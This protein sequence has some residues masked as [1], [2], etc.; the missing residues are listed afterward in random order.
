M[1]RNT[2]LLAVLLGVFPPAAAQRAPSINQVISGTV[3]AADGGDVQGTYVIFCTVVNND[4]D[5]SRADVVQITDSGS[6]ADFTSDALPDGPYIVLAW[7][8][9]EPAGELGPEDNVGDYRP[10]QQT[11]GVIRPPAADVEITLAGY[12]AEAADSSE[13]DNAGDTPSAAEAALLVGQW[14]SSSAATGGYYNTQT[15]SFSSA[16]GNGSW[17]E[18]RPDGT[19]VYSSYIESVLYNCLT[20]FFKYQTGT[21][22]VQGDQVV[23]TTTS[24]RKKFENTCNTSKNYDQAFVPEPDRYTWSVYQEYGVDTLELREDPSQAGM[25]FR[26]SP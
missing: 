17:Y 26:R 6:Q 4:C 16:G 10:D 24:G 13:T 7:Q 19:F 1:F 21:V 22:A 8:D 18:I 20:S 25:V 23:F 2:A 5:R 9:N 12:D 15:G 11:T 3:F 14:R